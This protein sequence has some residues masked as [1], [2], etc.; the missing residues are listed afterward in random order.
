MTDNSSTN[1]NK[2]PNKIINPEL[3]STRECSQ[4]TLTIKNYKAEGGLSQRFFENENEQF[5][6]TGPMGKGLGLDTE[7]QGLHVAFAAGT[8]ILVFVDLIAKLVLQ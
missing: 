4:I 5:K 6:I 1:Q 7:S 3:L 8:G 2:F